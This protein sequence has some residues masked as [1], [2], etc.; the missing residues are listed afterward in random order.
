ME[1]ISFY[2]FTSLYL[3]SVFYHSMRNPEGDSF[4]GGRRGPWMIHSSFLEMKADSDTGASL[5][6]VYTG[7]PY[8]FQR[9]PGTEEC[10]PSETELMPP[11]GSR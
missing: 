9:V 8:V 7:H 2:L 11:Q 6:L 3:L 1:I 5:T 10:V 4:Y